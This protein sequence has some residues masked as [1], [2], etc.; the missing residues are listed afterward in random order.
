L[1][2]EEPLSVG[3]ED[4]VFRRGVRVRSGDRWTSAAARCP[5]S[6][7]DPHAYEEHK[8]STS[9]PP[10]VPQTTR[11]ADQRLCVC[12]WLIG[13]RRAF[14]QA[15]HCFSLGDGLDHRDDLVGLVSL[16][17]GES[18]EFLDPCH[19]DAALGSARDGDTAAASELEHPL[20]AQVA[21]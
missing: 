1:G 17:T 4:D 6:D 7:A 8:C 15:L 12:R 10:S 18:D 14:V 19:D 2:G 16:L 9:R 21:Y 5:N 20:V 3:G 13:H 11:L